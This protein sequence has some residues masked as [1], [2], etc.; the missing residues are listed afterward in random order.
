MAYYA[1]ST[2]TTANDLITAIKDFATAN[3]WTIDNYTTGTYNRLHL[4]KGAQ[5]VDM[6]AVNT[7]AINMYGCTGYASGS[8]YSAQPGTS[9]VKNL[10]FTAGNIYYLVSTVGGLFLI[11]SYSSSTFHITGFFTIQE[12]IGAWSDGACIVG[13]YSSGPTF[14]AQMYSNA[15][16]FINGA[17]SATKA[18]NGLVGGASNDNVTKAQPCQYNAAIVPIPLPLFLAMS[19][20]STKY[21]PLG[22][23]PGVFRC[24]GGDI[25]SALDILTIGTDQYM[26]L[27]GSVSGMGG[28]DYDYLFKLG[29]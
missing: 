3:G 6:Q 2:F 5:H 9:A 27:P 25:Y 16:I 11:Y 1:T 20:D 15:Q 4:H 10:N 14:S 13:P 28:T 23:A 17:W 24:N 21:Q 19:T 18:A 26:I 29:A 12:K 22:F 8:A 7:A